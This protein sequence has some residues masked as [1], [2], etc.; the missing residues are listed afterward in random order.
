MNIIPILNE[1][2]KGALV[3]FA[4]GDALGWPN[5]RRAMSS[6]YNKNYISN[7]KEWQKKSGGRYWWHNEIIMPGEY[8]DD[9]QLTLAIARSLLSGQKWTCILQNT[10]C[11]IG[12][13]M[14]EAEEKL[15]SKQRLFGL[16]IFF[17]GKEEK[18][19]YIFPQGETALRCESSRM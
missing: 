6:S 1:K 8:S 10:N 5:E 4:V 2:S 19:I 9:T 15:S 18:I 17:L 13:N 11:H 3:S 7:F 16:I 14:R 12:N